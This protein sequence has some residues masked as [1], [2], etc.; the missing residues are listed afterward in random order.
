MMMAEQEERCKVLMNLAQNEYF[1]YQSLI[2]HFISLAKASHMV[3]VTGKNMFFLLLVG[4]IEKL[5]SK[6]GRYREE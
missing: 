1:W 5:E 4:K 3:Q 6:E 2:L